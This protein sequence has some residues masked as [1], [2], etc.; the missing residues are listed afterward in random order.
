[1]RTV[2]AFLSD[3]HLGDAMLDLAPTMCYH[4][5]LSSRHLAATMWGISVY[6][7]LSAITQRAANLSEQKSGNKSMTDKPKEDKGKIKADSHFQRHFDL[8]VSTRYFGRPR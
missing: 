7:T 4:A 2:G 3:E 5:F 8:G 6:Q 1:M